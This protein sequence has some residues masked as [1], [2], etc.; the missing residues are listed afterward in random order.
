MPTNNA[1]FDEN[2]S[3]Q[4]LAFGKLRAVEHDRYLVV[5]GTT[6]ISAVIAPDG[7]ELARTDFFQPAYLDSQIRLKSDLTPATQWG[8]ALQ[9]VL[10][11]LGI[12]ALVAAI[13]HN[14]GFVQRM[15]RRRTGEG[16]RR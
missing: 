8:P 11:T 4:Q 10:V 9:V 5:A 14:G 13:L 16:P 15:L 3:A 6:G 7:R 12:G 2:M 1:T